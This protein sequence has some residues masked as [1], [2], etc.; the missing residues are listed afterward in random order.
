MVI[1]GLW[2]AATISSPVAAIGLARRKLKNRYSSTRTY[3]WRLSLACRIRYA[4]PSSKSSSNPSHSADQPRNFGNPFRNLSK[5]R[6]GC[7]A[8]PKKDRVW[9]SSPTATAAREQRIPNAGAPEKLLTQSFAQADRIVADQPREL[10]RNPFEDK[11]TNTPEK[12]L[13]ESFP[14]T[15][16]GRSCAAN[17][18]NRRKKDVEGQKTPEPDLL[19]ISLHLVSAG[20]TYRPRF[21]SNEYS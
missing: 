16:R 7:H 21:Q 11:T 1:S 13:L 17:C 8:T 3:R 12:F 6:L 15:T 20:P 2:D 10:R 14:M 9:P 18:G 5:T 19:D 4:A